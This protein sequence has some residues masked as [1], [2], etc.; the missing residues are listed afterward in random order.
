MA[1]QEGPLDFGLPTSQSWR[2]RRPGRESAS[3]LW[4]QMFRLHLYTSDENEGSDF[5]STH[6]YARVIPQTGR[7]LVSPTSYT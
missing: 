6:Q 5:D 2:A 7:H 3:T 4:S 1:L